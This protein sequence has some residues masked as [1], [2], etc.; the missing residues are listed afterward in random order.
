ML[1]TLAHLVEF[2]DSPLLRR[3]GI[4]FGA[5]V[6]VCE[7]Y[8]TYPFSYCKVPNTHAC[9]PHPRNTTGLSY[10][11]L[12][13]RHGLLAGLGRVVKALLGLS[14]VC[15]TP[16]NAAYDM[17]V[18][19]ALRINKVK[20]PERLFVCVCVRASMHGRVFVWKQIFLET[21]IRMDCRSQ[22][23]PKQPTT[24]TTQ[25][26][27]T[28][29]GLFYFSFVGTCPR[30]RSPPAQGPQQGQGCSDSRSPFTPPTTA[31]GE[32]QPQSQWL[33]ALV[34]GLA[35]RLMAWHV[36]GVKFEV[37]VLIMTYRKGERYY[38]YRV[39]P[40]LGSL[41]LTLSHCPAQ[42]RT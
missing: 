14:N 26:T 12:S 38:M 3:S 28:Y 36:S 40:R 37:G 1:G 29:P 19:A 23:L 18:H 9:H 13:R 42:S 21:Q 24:T 33:T 20:K 10:F 34:K 27:T 8:Y 17:T 4:D 6:C 31:T 7:S 2:A 25:V 15:S 32:D 5:S 11:R 35:Y 22:T 16:D 41:T 39:L 30:H